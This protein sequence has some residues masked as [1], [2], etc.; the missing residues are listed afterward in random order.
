MSVDK[1]KLIEEI[2][3]HV[4]LIRNNTA[5]DLCELRRYKREYC[6]LSGTSV[7]ME[8]MMAFF[9]GRVASNKLAL[10]HFNWL[11]QSINTMEELA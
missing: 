10:N 8:G 4:H 1:M 6:G 9:R 5:E 2:N 3:H 11:K 7:Y